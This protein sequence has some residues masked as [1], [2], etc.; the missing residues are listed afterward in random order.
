MLS[1][2]ILRFL[3]LFTASIVAVFFFAA[4]SHAGSEVAGE[5]EPSPSPTPVV[6]Q[7]MTA[8]VG[9]TAEPGG[10]VINTVSQQNIVMFGSPTPEP[11]PTPPVIP[12]D[13]VSFFITSDRS[14]VRPGGE[15]T[16]RLVIR[17]TLDHEL[18]GVTVVAHIPEFLIPL[19]VIP[20]A[21]DDPAQ[22]TII[23][24]DQTIPAHS[25]VTLFLNAQADFSAP[26]GFALRVVADMSGPDIHLSDEDVTIVEVFA[27]AIA[28]EEIHITPSKA[29]PVPVT[30]RTGS[31]TALLSTLLLTSFGSIGALVRYWWL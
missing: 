13:F 5:Y 29:A 26:D 16:Y 21:D 2:S 7:G 1:S 25:E 11:T 12:S 8:V 10:T 30:A 23:W 9:G 18:S 24:T 3:Y 6:E 15:L 14:V 19:A 17:N 20:P 22:R 4:A 31:S 27:P 28:E